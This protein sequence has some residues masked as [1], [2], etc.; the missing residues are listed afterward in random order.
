MSQPNNTPNTISYPIRVTRILLIIFDVLVLV[1]VPLLGYFVGNLI[2]MHMSVSDIQQGYAYSGLLYT[3]YNATHNLIYYQESQVT[4]GM[5]IA[6]GQTD[7]NSLSMFGLI[8][9]IVADIA[10]AYLIV[11]EY[12][13]MDS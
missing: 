10:I 5:G 3:V 13:K 9:G 7:L 8:G 2:G 12:E 11:R 6:E 1:G 4:Q